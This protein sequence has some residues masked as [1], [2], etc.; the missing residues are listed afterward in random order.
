MEAEAFYF[1]VFSWFDDKIVTKR[2]TSDICM[3][4]RVLYKN[5][6]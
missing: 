3:G 5:V 1:L 4:E 2:K 6:P